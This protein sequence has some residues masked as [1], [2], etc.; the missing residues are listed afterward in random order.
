MKD[1][2]R[3]KYEICLSVTLYLT[4]HFHW[5]PIW[6]RLHIFLQDLKLPTLLNMLSI[7]NK[8]IGNRLALEQ[9]GFNFTVGVY[10]LL[11]FLYNL[12]HLWC[13]WSIESRSIRS[14]SVG[15]LRRKTASYDWLE[16]VSHSTVFWPLLRTM[17]ICRVSMRTS[18]IIG[19][20]SLFKLY[21]APR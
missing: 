6:C 9:I 5:I 2:G 7:T 4:H 21:R 1:S 3:I 8:K 20:L 17:I 13:T 18:L 19:L 15:Y 10:I 12:R 16:R 11:S 14:S